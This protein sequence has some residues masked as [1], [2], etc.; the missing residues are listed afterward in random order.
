M[1]GE[2]VARIEHRVEP[3]RSA[4]YGGIMIVVVAARVVERAL[5]DVDLHVDA[6]RHPV[7]LHQLERVDLVGIGGN[8]VDGHE[9]LLPVGAQAEALAVLLVQADLVEQGVRLGRLVLGELLGRLLIVPG[10]LGPGSELPGLALAE[11]DDV[12]DLLAVDAHRKRLPELL[13]REEL[14]LLGVLVRDVQVDLHHLAVG[15]DQVEQPVA[16]LLHAL[17]QAS[18][19]SARCRYGGPAGRAGRTPRRASGIRRPGR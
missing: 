17:R 10:M 11:E 16:A 4:P 12:D 9:H 6:D 3:A 8:D 13:V 2:E 7:P 15:V 14:A 5:D 1:L 18:A 19:C